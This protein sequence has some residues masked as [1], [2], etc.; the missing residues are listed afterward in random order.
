MRLGVTLS[1]QIVEHRTISN[2]LSYYFCTLLSVNV[3]VPGAVLDY[4]IYFPVNDQIPASASLNT[5]AIFSSLFHR[6]SLKLRPLNLFSSP[7]HM[8]DPFSI[9][10][11]FLERSSLR[12]HH[13]TWHCLVH[14]RWY[15]TSSKLTMASARA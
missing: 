6:N 4:L 5:R 13:R 12:C 10:L 1:L 15:T 14:Y 7:P 3:Y 11:V 2:A 8:V 9:Y